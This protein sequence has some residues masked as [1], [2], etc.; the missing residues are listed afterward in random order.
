M[1]LEVVKQEKSKGFMNYGLCD[2][3]RAG[4]S[5]YRKLVTRINKRRVKNAL[6][7]LRRTI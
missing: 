4:I 3:I 7:Y 5:V 6:S 2:D 1:T